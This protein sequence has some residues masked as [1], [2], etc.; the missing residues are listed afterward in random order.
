MCVGD[1][2]KVCVCGSDRMSCTAKLELEFL[3]C[4]CNN[5][6]NFGF[7]F[8]FPRLLVMVASLLHFYGFLFFHSALLFY[9]HQH[10]QRTH[11]QTYNNSNKQN[12]LKNEHIKNIVE[13]QLKKSVLKNKLQVLSVFFQFIATFICWPFSNNSNNNK[14][15]NNTKTTH[16]R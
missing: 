16:T 1:V 2:S 3:F 7:G 15:M 5:E 14:N 9:Y 6:M 13:T 4:K 10:T 11:T 8:G 12:S